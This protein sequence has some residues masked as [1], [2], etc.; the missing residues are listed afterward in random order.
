MVGEQEHPLIKRQKNYVDQMRTIGTDFGLSP[1]ARSK[2]AI[3]RTQ[4]K[5]EATAAEKVFDNV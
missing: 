4:E 3:T 1:I 5:R 2:L